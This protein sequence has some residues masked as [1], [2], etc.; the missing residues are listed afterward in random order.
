VTH[1]VSSLQV[2]KSAL[3]PKERKKAKQQTTR[4]GRMIAMTDR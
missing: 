4:L 2:P 3:R 1:S